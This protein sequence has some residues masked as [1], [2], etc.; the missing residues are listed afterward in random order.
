MARSQSALLPRTTERVLSLVSMLPVT[1]S[2]TWLA[3]SP[4]LLTTKELCLDYKGFECPLC[5]HR[6]DHRIS[7]LREKRRRIERN[8]MAASAARRCSPTPI[9]SPKVQNSRREASGL[10]PIGAKECLGVPGLPDFHQA[11]VYRRHSNCCG[12]PPSRNR[13]LTR[14]A[15]RPPSSKA[16]AVRLQSHGTEAH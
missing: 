1:T 8:S 9:N 4:H 15:R 11:V 14:P 2:R 10:R 16:A 6:R 12:R 3:G 7:I 13:E 5:G